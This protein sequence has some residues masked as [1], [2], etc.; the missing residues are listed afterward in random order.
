VAEQNRRGKSERFDKTNDV[1]RV[2]RGT[3]THE[4]V[5]S[6]SRDPWRPA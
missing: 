3:D 5:R 2:D 4:A 1:A 6:T